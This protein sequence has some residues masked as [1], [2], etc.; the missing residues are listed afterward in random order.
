MR[1]PQHRVWPYLL[2]GLVI[3]RPDQ[4]WCADITTS[5]AARLSLSGRRHGLVQPQGSGLAP[6]HTMEADFCIEALQ[7]AMARFGRPAIFN[8]DQ[9]SQFTSPRFTEVL[10]EAG[11]RISM[12]GRGALARQTCSS[13]GSGARSNTSVYLNAFETGSEARAAHQPVGS[14]TIHGSRLTRPW[15]DK[16]RPRSIWPPPDRN[17]GVTEIRTK[18]S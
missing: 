10:A 3:D 17:G 12:D 5:D 16:R 18:L 1:H 7:E 9:G 14:P 2:R 6:V 4:V 8:T 13:S 15:A 11:V